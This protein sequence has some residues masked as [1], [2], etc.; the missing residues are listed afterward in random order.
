MRADA[1][2]RW[3]NLSNL[4]QLSYTKAIF[5]AFSPSMHFHRRAHLTSGRRRTFQEEWNV[6]GGSFSL[7]YLKDN[8]P[9]I[10]GIRNKAMTEVSRVVRVRSGW[11]LVSSISGANRFSVRYGLQ[12]PRSIVVR[13]QDF[14][15]YLKIA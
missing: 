1:E 10:Y 2:I 5:N 15:N 7:K 12:S 8:E 14:V 3:P 13:A 6:E 9:A 11:T 4:I